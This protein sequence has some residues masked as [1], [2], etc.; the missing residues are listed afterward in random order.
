MPTAINTDTLYSRIL[1][2]YG[3]ATDISALPNFQGGYINFGYW[4]NIPYRQ[5]S[6]ISIED[7]IQS[8]A[9]LYE[10]VFDLL[11]IQHNETVLEIGCGKGLGCIT[12]LHKFQPTKIIGLDITPKQIARAVSLHS[13]TLEVFPQL[14]FQ[15]GAAEDTNLSTGSINKI[16]SIEAAQHFSSMEKVA[17]EMARILDKRGSAVFAAHLTTTPQNTQKILENNLFVQEK[18]D[19]LFPIQTVI[20]AF[21]EAGFKKVL[22]HSIGQYV[23]EGFDRWLQQNDLPTPWSHNIYKAYRKGWLDYYVITTSIHP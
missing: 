21:Q 6:P 5:H 22:F 10:L 7:R 15:L 23:F 12:A 11:N 13:S 18:I 8:S 16:Y 19:N 14:S 4:K 17:V 2:A 9:A 20:S 3:G 1:D